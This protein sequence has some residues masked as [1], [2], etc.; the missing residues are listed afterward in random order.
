MD[1]RDTATYLRTYEGRYGLRLELAL[2]QLPPK[3]RRLLQKRVGAAF[4]RLS[5][6]LHHLSVMNDM[7]LREPMAQDRLDHYKGMYHD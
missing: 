3:Q 7:L 1:E 4:W 2:S 5:H 6:K